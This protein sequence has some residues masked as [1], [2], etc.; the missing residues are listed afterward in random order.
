MLQ[1]AFAS[2]LAARANHQYVSAPATP[3]ARTLSVNALSAS[4]VFE[5]SA[6]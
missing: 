2:A 5:R 1:I 3:R 4:G 6:R